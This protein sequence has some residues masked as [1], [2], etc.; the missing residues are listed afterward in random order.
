MSSNHDLEQAI[1]K[2]LNIFSAKELIHR[3]FEAGSSLRLAYI[4][5]NNV[6]EMCL[7]LGITDVI[8]LLNDIE[9]RINELISTYDS[10]A[11]QILKEVP[12]KV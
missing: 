5:I 9:R 11:K 8:I 7:K 3:I 10:I 1:I 6:K 4:K 12:H 2:I